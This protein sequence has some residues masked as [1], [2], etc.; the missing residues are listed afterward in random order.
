MNS[1]P[2]SGPVD[3]GTFRNI[4]KLVSPAVV[5]IRSTSTQRAQEMSEFFGGGGGGG[6]TNCSSASSA[7]R[8]GGRQ[9]QQPRQRQPREQETQAAGTGFV[10][11]KEGFILTNNHVIDGA[12]KIEV[13]FFGEDGDVY[14][15]AK[16]IGRDPLTDSALMQLME[17]KSDL[18]EVKFG[19]SS[20]MQP[21]DWVD[22]DRQSRSASA[23]R[24]ASA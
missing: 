15:E 5:N 4:A 20:Q 12:T 21:G 11:S 6:T 24:S 23:T 22:G 18:V 17:A 8:A 14:H 13:G 19:D 3:A 9:P 1:A 7:A 2:L 10:I 16:L